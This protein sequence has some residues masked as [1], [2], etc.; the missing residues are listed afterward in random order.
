MSGVRSMG[1]PFLRVLRAFCAVCVTQKCFLTVRY[2]WKNVF[3]AVRY[4]KRVSLSPC[5]M[6]KEPRTVFALFAGR[7]SL[8]HQYIHAVHGESPE[9]REISG[10]VFER[11]L[12][13]KIRRFSCAESTSHACF[14]AVEFA[15]SLQI[16]LCFSAP[17][18]LTRVPGYGKIGKNYFPWENPPGERRL[19]CPARWKTSKPSSER[20][21]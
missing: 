11:G 9:R 21:S 17:L 16:P 3:F 6:R 4:A 20:T 18:C 12:S 7:R 14:Q 2:E 10:E 8:L 1:N 5:G 15:E 13:E 19:P